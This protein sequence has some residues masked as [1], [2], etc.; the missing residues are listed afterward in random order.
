MSENLPQHLK[1]Y[2]VSQ[3]YG[4]Y[5]PVDQACWRF[6]LRQLKD[7][8]SK[9]AHEC[10]IE[11]LEKTGI[12]LEQ[13][14]R[15]EEISKKLEKFG[16]RAL[17][18]SGFIPPAAFMELQSL[19]V[20]PIASDMRTIEHLTYTPAPDIVHEAAG[21]APILIHPE[22]AEYLKKYSQVARKAIISSEDLAIYEAIRDLSDIKE[23][24]N[25]TEDEISKAQKNL[26]LVTKSVSHV[27][28]A[29]QV[30]RM[31]WWTAEYGLIG[32]L[33]SPKI[34]GAGLLSS[35]AESKQ[36]LSE[37]VK[38]V[39]MSLKAVE[40]T[41]DI[42]EQ[43][44]QLFV[45]PD[46]KTLSKILDEFSETMAFKM[47][48]DSGL[49]KAKKA[50]T[51]NTVVLD[52]GLQLSGKLEEFEKNAQYLK[53]SGPCQIS[54]QD[55]ELIGHGKDYH[56]SGFST[57]LGKV[58]DSR[59][60]NLSRL[61]LTELDSLGFREG[62][63]VQIEF[64]SGIFLKGK[65]L[66]RLRLENKNVLWSFT[67]C[68]VWRGQ[69]TLFD[70]SWGTFDLAIADKVI[71]VFGGPADR[72][73]FGDFEDFVAKKVP[74]LKYSEAQK[75]QQVFYQ[76]VRFLREEKITGDKLSSEI[77]KVFKEYILKNDQEWLILLECY[78]LA[79]NRIEEKQWQ[80]KLK[81]ELES[82]ALKNP[83]FKDLIQEGLR[84]SASI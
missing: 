47:G 46:F 49:E 79:L 23:N 35:V 72:V 24:P 33:E 64:E 9:N 3:N 30:S 28:E 54:F 45:T 41:Y 62:Q 48:G 65:L 18:V 73:A 17:P 77:E 50:K 11:G 63:E 75:E 13:I 38:K 12:T 29:T 83:N 15:I 14:P 69:T 36:S 39:P 22:F 20:L 10:Y 74:P 1:K 70:P 55:Q 76:R 61:S 78:E 2:I 82:R 27:S 71:S 40:T 51:V 57:P 59:F 16:W 52:T 26:E 43:Q 66:T 81:S 25:S 19:G 67:N 84:L 5:T 7:F 6:V 8:L 44:P 58:R 68:K 42:T 56:S 32:T 37:K 53:F 31:N 60:G 21:H 34:F 4:K 80:M